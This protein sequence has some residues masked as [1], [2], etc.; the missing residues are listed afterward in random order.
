MPVL[1]SGFCTAISDRTGYLDMNSAMLAKVE[2]KFIQ[3]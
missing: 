3:R 1:I 2:K